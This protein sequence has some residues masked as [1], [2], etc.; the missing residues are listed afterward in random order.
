[1]TES[2]ARKLEEG[3]SK[4]EAALKGTNEVI[5]AL[6]G[7]TLTTLGVFIPIIML[8][9][10]Q[11]SFFR[12]FAFTICFAI[13]FSFL[14]S[15]ILVPVISLLALDSTQFSRNNWAFRG[16]NSLEK[17]YTGVLRW[18]LHHISGLPWYL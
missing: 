14:S 9:G 4:Y 5:G 3:M 16:I 1:M 13:G 10:V 7:S 2:I 11:A 17:K 6:L 8:T 18:I 12:E 15:I